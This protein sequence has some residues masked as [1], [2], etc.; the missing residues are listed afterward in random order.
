MPQVV[1]DMYWGES[2]FDVKLYMVVEPAKV[3]IHVPPP[4]GVPPG[5]TVVVFP[6]FSLHGFSLPILVYPRH[7]CL[8][9]CMYVCSY[10]SEST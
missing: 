10:L 5:R 7:A 9:V 3:R 2:F 6:S 8:C 1:S 4:P